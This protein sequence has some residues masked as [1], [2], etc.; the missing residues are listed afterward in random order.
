[1]GYRRC[2][3]TGKRRKNIQKRRITG[4]VYSYCKW[5]LTDL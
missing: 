3:K 4:K 1:M 5:P 2:K